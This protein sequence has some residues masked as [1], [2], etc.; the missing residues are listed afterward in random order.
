MDSHGENDDLVNE[1]KK[2]LEIHFKQIDEEVLTYLIGIDL[3]LMYFMIFIRI[4]K[5]IKRKKE[6]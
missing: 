6:S 5:I 2:I 4:S 3:N 1:I